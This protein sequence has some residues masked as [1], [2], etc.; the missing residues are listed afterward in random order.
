MTH[1]PL[2]RPRK[3]RIPLRLSRG[4]QRFLLA[5]HILTVMSL[6]H[7][8]ALLFGEGRGEA[9]LYIEPYMGSVASSLVILWGGALGLDWLER[10][11]SEG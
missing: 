4:A 9:L 1:S 8:A 7:F 3:W 10:T 11:R 2:N 5:G 6:C